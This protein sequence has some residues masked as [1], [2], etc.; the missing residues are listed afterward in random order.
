MATT[1]VTKNSSTASA[2]PTAAQ[3]VQG[4]LAV[5]VADKRLYTEDNAG[6][7]VE[8]GTNPSTIDINSGTIDGTTI[9]ASSA[10]TGAFTTLTASGEITANGGIAL[11]DGDKATF[12]ASDDLQIY[13]DGSHS[14]V[15]DY[16]TGNLSVTGNNLYLQNTSGE[17][18]L[19]GISDGAVSLYHNNATKLATTDTGIDV[20]GTATMDGLTVQNSGPT[21]LSVGSS[22][23]SGA[24][25]RL[26]GSA[27][28]DFVGG[29]YSVIKNEN[30]DLVLISGT[31]N[32][33][34]D[35]FTHDGSGN[36]LRHKIGSN[37]DISFYEDTGT[38]A[39][40][41]WDASAESLGI[42][43]SS[44]TSKLQLNE[45]SATD[46]TFTQ[47]NTVASTSLTQSANGSFYMYNYGAYNL[48]FGTNATERMRIDNNGN[49]GIGESSPSGLLHLKKASDTADIILESSGGSGK[50]YLIG[51]RTDGSLNFY[52]VTASTERLRIDSSGNVGIGTSSP[53]S[54]ADR[55]LHVTGGTGSATLKLS[56]TSVGNTN[57]DGFDVA[58]SG[59]NAYLINR[60]NGPMMFST[61]DI[62]RMRIDSSGNLLVGKTSLGIGV[63]GTE[64]RAGGQLLVTADSDNPADFNRKTTDGIIA[65]FRKDNATVGSI[66]TSSGYT[67]ITSGDG[68]NGSGL[69]FGDSKIY[70]VEANSVVTDNAVDFGDSNYRFKDLYLSGGVYLGGTGAANK[71]DDY[72]EGTWTPV[73]GAGG[74]T[75][76]SITYTATYTKIGNTVTLYFKANSTTGDIVVPN[77]QLWSGIPFTPTKSGTST[78]ITEDIDQFA[79]QGYASVGG[80]SFAVSACGSATGTNSLEASITYETA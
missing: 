63:T 29:D 75:G 78:V 58:H 18:Y 70:P 15:G 14:Y 72:E 7:V 54:Y 22:D 51:S 77:Y 66:G 23:G 71:L 56:S 34:I 31:P 11:G 67:K 38:T 45:G 17:T 65:L 62:E 25:L 1:I 73:A 46:V 59:V 35:S 68:T 9:G 2:V 33:D 6:A 44:P 21:L 41:F 40:L 42:G 12:G 5:N 13:H 28:G 37:G 27:N 24:Q 48:I 32:G 50:E 60:E 39:K 47:S 57:A 79:R 61:N 53:T 3:L 52:D 20:T 43:T 69:Q 19:S 30:N 8:L 4:E 26:D 36:K 64:V 74:M 16:G 49:V 10:S 55:T 80:T 76:T